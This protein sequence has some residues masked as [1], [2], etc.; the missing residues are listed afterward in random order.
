MRILVVNVWDK[1]RGDEALVRAIVALLR[2]VEP[3]CEIDLLPIYRWPLQLQM[4]NVT[5]LQG[6][7][8]CDYLTKSITLVDGLLNKLPRL[9]VTRRPIRVLRVGIRELMAAFVAGTGYRNLR[10]LQEYDYV[11]FAP[12]GQTIS[13]GHPFLKPA[14]FSLAAAKRYGIPY[15]I[16]GVTMGPF[17]GLSNR[18]KRKI[19]N[20]LMRAEAIVLREDISLQYLEKLL[21]DTS[22]VKAAVDIVFSL[23]E[24]RPA[25][26]DPTALYSERLAKQVEQTTIGAC[27]SLSRQQPPHETDDYRSYIEKYLAKMALFF[28]YVVGQTG[29]RLLLLPHIDKDYRE[30]NHIAQRMQHQ[31]MVEIVELGFDDRVHRHIISQLEFFIST[32]YHPTIFAI[33]G[34][35]PFMSAMQHFKV[36]GLLG[37][38]GIDGISCWQDDGLETYKDLFLRTWENRD[39]LGA[40][41]KAAKSRAQDMA[42]LYLRILRDKIR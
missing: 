10:F 25:D 39:T 32:R 20:V 27:I 37:K 2:Q 26:G 22:S 6:R 17:D 4:P 15:F 16:M 14:V 21:P 3:S 11:F 31:D 34:E 9:S 42:S 38:L 36:K 8:G 29:R 13:A 23:T 28:D 5:V 33:R 40:Q 12:Q 19:R 18:F 41:V 1:N 30:L 24:D 35:T 7:H